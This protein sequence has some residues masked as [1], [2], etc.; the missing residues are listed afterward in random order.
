M[1]IKSMQFPCTNELL[2]ERRTHGDTV[3]C[4][5]KDV[6]SR[7]PLGSHRPSPVPSFQ[8]LS[9]ASLG[10][11]NSRQGHGSTLKPSNAFLLN[12]PCQIPDGW[13][14]GRGGARTMFRQLVFPK[15]L[16]LLLQA[17]GTSRA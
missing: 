1:D 8:F 5:I 9:A 13:H 15:S 16:L 11:K 14:N 2:C 4:I 3:V 7:A 12:S 10:E 6:K 17:P